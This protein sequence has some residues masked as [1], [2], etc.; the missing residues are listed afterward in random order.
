M[1]RA[2]L[3][4]LTLLLVLAVGGASCE[5]EARQC[6]D[7]ADDL[8]FKGRHEAA[9]S[10]VE[11]ALESLRGDNSA[12][13]RP[14][15][16]EALWTAGRLTHLYLHQPRVALRYYQTLVE[17]YP[18]S[19]EAL[20]ARERMARIHVEDLDDRPASVGLY[21]ALIAT[22]TDSPE[23]PR[24]QHEVALGYYAQGNWTQARTEAQ[25]LLEKHEDSEYVDDALFLIGGAFQ[26]EEKLDE[27]LK[28][29]SRLHEEHAS[30]ILVP[31]AWVEEGNCL[32]RQGKTDEAIAA[33]IRA[34]ET[35]PDP[36]AVQ[37]KIARLKTRKKALVPDEESYQRPGH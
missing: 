35:H 18:T 33:Y 5:P 2:G 20:R 31:R 4:S 16:I 36:R 10:Q 15:R 27:A 8:S 30:S 11:K 21:Q 32:A 37:V 19:P 6:L 7:R 29:Y 17:D 22:D 24:W 26:A 34:L 9:M 13:A 14:L 1:K 23:A 12:E 25:V 3:V 28:A